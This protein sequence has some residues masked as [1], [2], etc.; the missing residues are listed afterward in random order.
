MEVVGGQGRKRKHDNEA[1][2]VIAQ[3]PRPIAKLPKCKSDEES[4]LILYKFEYLF[5]YN[6]LNQDGQLLRCTTQ[7]DLSEVDPHFIG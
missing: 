2:R 6:P 5:C 1:P 3:L 4:G 7:I